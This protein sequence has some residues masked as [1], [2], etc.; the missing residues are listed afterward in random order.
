MRSMNL[1]ASVVLAS[2][3][4]A[5]VQLGC[6]SDNSPTAAPA[7][8]PFDSGPV[9]VPSAAP[10]AAA[11]TINVGGTGTVASEDAIA[12]DG[13]ALNG[14]V[15]CSATGGSKCSAAIGTT[16][17]AIAGAG[18]KFNGWSGGGATISVDDSL[19]ITPA[20]PSPLQANFVATT[21][22]NSPTPT[23]ADAGGGG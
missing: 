6:S 18:F 9:A 13:G 1:L 17:W 11:V 14:S 23:P 20:T 15:V 22:G 5:G 21:T 7:Y 19:A 16:V 4:V 10:A 12:V 8:T 2:V 3:A